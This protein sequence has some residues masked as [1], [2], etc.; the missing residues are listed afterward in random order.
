MHLHGDCKY[1]TQSVTTP[2]SQ[3]LH[4]SGVAGGI[5]GSLGAQVW[6]C[7]WSCLCRM[8]VWLMHL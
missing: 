6:T 2:L 8:L 5:I 7:R 1:G 4:R 3:E